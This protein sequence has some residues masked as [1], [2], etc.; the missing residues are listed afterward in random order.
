MYNTYLGTFKSLQIKFAGM[1][2]KE[3]LHSDMTGIKKISYTMHALLTLQFNSLFWHY[4]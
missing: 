2:I 3:Q 4:H 1:S